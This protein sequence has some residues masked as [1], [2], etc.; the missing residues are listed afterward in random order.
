MARFK[1]TVA[2][3]EAKLITKKNTVLVMQE[4]VQVI[5][6]KSGVAEQTSVEM[7]PVDGKPTRPTSISLHE[8]HDDEDHT[9]VDEEHDGVTFKD[10][11]QILPTC[12]ILIVTVII[13]VTVIPYAFSSVIKQLEAA[14][15][16]ADW[17]KQQEE[18]KKQAVEN[19]NE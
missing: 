18:L 14:N 1:N 5:L 11:K 16:I 3:V 10:I 7:N 2:D 12:L 4:D 17:R 9:E 13:M 8:D 6:S 19:T 15:Q